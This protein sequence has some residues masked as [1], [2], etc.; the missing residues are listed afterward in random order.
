MHPATPAHARARAPGDE[1]TV[2]PG[3]RGACRL[4]HTHAHRSSAPHA[5]AGPD[6]VENVV[7]VGSG[8]AGYTA[9]IYAA[10]ANL[11][12]VVFEGLQNGRGGQLMTTT[13]VRIWPPAPCWYMR[14]QCWTSGH[15]PQAARLCCWQLS[16]Q[17][18]VLDALGGA[19]AR[20]AGRLGGAAASA[21]HLAGA[22]AAASRAG[23]AASGTAGG[24]T[25][26]EASPTASPA[27][28]GRHGPARPA[29]K[30]CMHPCRLG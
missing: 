30:R 23:T 25:S 4:P 18:Q 15:L 21:D 12:P 1:E 22:A 20:R 2:P 16:S 17:L 11:K 27:V 7:I 28:P 6:D 13:E 14:R 5:S 29:M 9:A 3:D 19:A 8:P 10:R 24:R 26:Q